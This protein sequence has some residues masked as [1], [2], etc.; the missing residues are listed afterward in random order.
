MKLGT[1][2]LLVGAVGTVC[3]V[4]AL[5]SLAAPRQ[6]S[7]VQSDPAREV[8]GGTVT[9]EVSPVIVKGAA[10]ETAAAIAAEAAADER[11]CV[12]LALCLD[13]SGSM[14]DLID[15][16]RQKLWAIV[17]DL[18]L[19]R[20]TPRLEVALLTFGNDGH[21][22]ERGWVKLDIPFTEDLDLVSQQ[23]FALTTNGGTE[24]V[25]RVMRA[26]LEQL[27]WSESHDDLKMIVVAGN[28][29]ATQDPDLV[30]TE[31]AKA[32]IERGILV[33]SVYCGAESDPIAAAWHEVARRADG[34]FACID[35]QK[36]TVAIDTPFDEALMGL[37]TELNGTYLWFGEAGM[38]ACENQVAQDSN[39][40]GHNNDAL[41]GRARAKSSRLYWNGADL[42]DAL[43]RDL[44]DL[45]EVKEE[46]LP[47]ELRGKSKEEIEALIAKR[48]EDRAAVQKQIQELS[49]KREAFLTEERERLALDT[50]DAFDAAIRMAIREQARAKGMAF[51]EDSVVAETGESAGAEASTGTAEEAAE[52]GDEVGEEATSEG[53]E[54]AGVGENAANTGSPST[55]VQIQ[56]VK[57]TEQPRA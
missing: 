6:E 38:V 5:D 24:Y 15:S 20:P 7:R 37:N 50:S 13:T 48:K 10:D 17:N 52:A 36:G 12:Q 53:T 26:S 29:E 47:E 1:K 34:Q 28:E 54:S 21:D 31:V 27:A 8:V 25:A 19:A 3:A 30:A 9:V 40:L 43:E 2:F 32:A 33:N 49:E 14:D 56:K 46:D 57:Q 23:L 16:A 51:A 22:E 35:Q 55:P 4:T 18:A 41:V 42:V 39:A 11:P 44:V 45:D